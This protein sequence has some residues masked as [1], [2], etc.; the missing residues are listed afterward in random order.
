MPNFLGSQSWFSKNFARPIGN[1]QFPG[2]SAESISSGMEKLKLLHQQVLPFILRREKEQVLQ[3]LPPKCI[4]DIPC[5]LSREQQDLYEKFCLRAEARSALS[6]LQKTTAVSGN[7]N[8]VEIDKGAASS[9]LGDDALRSLLYLRLL[10]T[11]PSLVQGNRHSGS[12]SN[13]LYAHLDSSGK[14]QVLNELLRSAHI[15]GDELAAADNDTSVLYCDFDEKQ[16][17]DEVS[18]VLCSYDDTSIGGNAFATTGQVDTPKGTKCL[19][20]AQFTQSLDVVE[21]VLFQPHMPSLRYLR[22][23]GTI[24]L[25]RRG[26]IVETFNRD[27]S[28]KVM[29]LTTRVGGLGLNLTGKGSSCD[30]FALLQSR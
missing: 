27:D 24:P 18:S 1:G 15:C 13:N 2:A 26:D 23:D 10:C 17:G 6:A 29:L 11:H 8:K 21:R 9:T 22:L 12:G 16:G 19:I 30:R 20:F 5:T 14:L 4:T 7:G 3:E 28:I 25:E